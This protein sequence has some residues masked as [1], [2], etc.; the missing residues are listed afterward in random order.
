MWIQREVDK[1]STW[2]QCRFVMGSTQS[3]IDLLFG[4]HGEHCPPSASIQ[5]QLGDK[6]ADASRA[7]QYRLHASDDESAVEGKWSER[8]YPSLVHCIWDGALVQWHEAVTQ[9]LVLVPPAQ[10]D[11]SSQDKGRS[12]AQYHIT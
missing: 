2:I 7:K 4:I 10:G 5:A 9:C 11:H 6:E 12:K 3:R 1:G 8:T